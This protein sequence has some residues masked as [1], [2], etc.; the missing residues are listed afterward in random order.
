MNVYKFGGAS[1]KDKK[2]SLDRIIYNI[3]NSLQSW[4]ELIIVASAI[5]KT[6]NHLEKLIDACFNNSQHK[7]EIFEEIK[8]YHYNYIEECFG[9][10]YVIN[11]IRLYLNDLYNKVSTNTLINDYDS[12]YDSIVCYGELLSSRIVFEYIKKNKTDIK[13]KFVDI[14]NHIVTDKN[15][16]DAKIDFEKSAKPI[17]A[18]FSDKECTYVTQGYIGRSTDGQTTTL[19]REGSDYS[20]SSLAN[21]LNASVTLWKDVPGFMTADPNSSLG[22][23]ARKIDNLSYELALDMAF[24]GAKIM[25]P[26]T[27]Y[28]LK[29]KNLTLKIRPFNDD[30]NNGTLISEQK[31][32]STKLPPIFIIKEDLLLFTINM[33]DLSFINVENIANILTIFNNN[34]GKVLLMQNSSFGF[35]VVCGN[36]EKTNLLE[37]LQ[38][39]L[40]KKYRV[41]SNAM[42][43]LLTTRKGNNVE[44]A[45]DVTKEILKDKK[46]ILEQHSRNVSQFIFQDCCE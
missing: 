9:K 28:P 23:F 4:K 20:A 39:V 41:K 40:L 38:K 24:Y 16:R 17:E 30:N 3:N 44:I 21:I 45:E 27:I 13:L 15:H 36:D 42:L 7:I 33:K 22:K 29:D 8:L 32:F 34:K 35:N 10:D 5:D 26:K 12:F 43:S 6:T 31:E 19:G 1:L 14:R 11:D 2:K 18:A 46:I 37:R 25:H